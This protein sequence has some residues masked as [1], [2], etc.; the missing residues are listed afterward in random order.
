MNGAVG[1]GIV[2]QLLSEQP[3][4][5]QNFSAIEKCCISRTCDWQAI[6]IPQTNQ[7]TDAPTG[8]KWAGRGL[9]SKL[10][11]TEASGAN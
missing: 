6:L 10:A 2:R 8:Q 3:L 9:K 4:L 11:Y 1:L 5:C 7:G